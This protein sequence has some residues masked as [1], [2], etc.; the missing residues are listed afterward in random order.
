MTNNDF[1]IIFV[2]N[3]QLGK[4][5]ARLART[6]GDEKALEVYLHLLIHAFNITSNLQVDKAVFY[7]NFISENDIWEQAGY[8][9]FLQKGRN[10]GA[11][12]MNAFSMGF[13]RGYDK[14][15]FMSSSCAELSSVLIKE[16][17]DRLNDVNVVIG[18]ATEGG[19]YL[20]GMRKYHKELFKNK[21]W[22]TENLLLDIL[23]DLNR[24]KLTY[25]IL[26]TLTEIEE[27]KDL[28]L[29]QKYK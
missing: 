13:N 3:P 14:V 23:L 16:A 19:Y 20:F 4:V 5:K 7:S 2:D 10:M 26:P 11:R 24:F 27:E 12:M 8:D 22:N 25:T 21:E 15:V 1:L 6:V 17:F 29:M 28:V 9:Q 18:P